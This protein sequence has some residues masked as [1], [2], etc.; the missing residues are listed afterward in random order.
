MGREVKKR[1][2]FMIKPRQCPK[3]GS[4]NIKEMLYGLPKP[5]FED[6][7]QFYLAGCVVTDNDPKWIC[8]NLACP[9]LLA[10]KGRYKWGKRTG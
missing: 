10:H 9:H 6:G 2:L 4:E 8:L 7:K 3:C 1:N 5:D